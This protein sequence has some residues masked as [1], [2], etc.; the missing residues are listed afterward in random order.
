MLASSTNMYLNPGTARQS[1]LA[2]TV[3]EKSA[4]TIK[5]ASAD[6][7]N[8]HAALLTWFIE[9]R[10]VRSMIYFRHRP[11]AGDG[12]RLLSGDEVYL[13]QASTEADGI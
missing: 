5:T 11:T 8:L 3:S 2:S 13:N 7:F 4:I 1:R 10:E 9:H 6:F 12:D